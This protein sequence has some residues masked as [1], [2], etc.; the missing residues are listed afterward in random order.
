MIDFSNEKLREKKGK[1]IF[2][3][4]PIRDGEQKTTFTHHRV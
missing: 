1:T 3:N 4:L 2:I